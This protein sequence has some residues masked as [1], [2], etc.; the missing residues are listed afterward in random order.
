MQLAARF[1]SHLTTLQLPP[2]SYYTLLQAQYHRVCFQFSWC[3]EKKRVESR[4]AI[5][6]FYYMMLNIGCEF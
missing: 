6:C 2:T 4:W 1:A 3:S 5:R